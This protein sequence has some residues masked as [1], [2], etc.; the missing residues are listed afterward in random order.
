[1]T[2]RDLTLVLSPDDARL[3]GR[4]VDQM[5][6]GL[7]MIQTRLADDVTSTAIGQHL[8]DQIDDDLTSLRPIQNILDDYIE[9]RLIA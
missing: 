7:T 4:T 1:M 8:I 6:S 9:G 5:I 2:Q 3:M